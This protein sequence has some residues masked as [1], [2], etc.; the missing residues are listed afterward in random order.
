MNCEEV[1]NRYL[2]FKVTFEELLIN[3]ISKPL[4][5]Q[6]RI[7]EFAK[8][9]VQLVR[10]N[11]NTVQNAEREEYIEK[12][13]NGNFKWL[14]DFNHLYDRK[15]FNI[16]SLWEDMEYK[17]SKYFNKKNRLEDEF[18]GRI[19]LVDKHYK[20]IVNL[21]TY[22]REEFIRTRDRFK[23]EEAAEFLSGVN[24][25][26]YE[27]FRVNFNGN[28]L[29]IKIGGKESAVVL[30]SMFSMFVDFITIL[31][32]NIVGKK[33][34]SNDTEYQEYKKSKFNCML[35]HLNQIFNELKTQYYFC[36]YGIHNDNYSPDFDYLKNTGVFFGG[37][38]VKKE[39]EE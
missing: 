29:R 35:L 39:F 20:Q 16:T 36:P 23:E 11:C 18:D 27:I 25:I 21:I 38:K 13:I 7:I 17:Y 15:M 31:L 9:M 2:M 8:D 1:I 3:P 22:F 24:S 37:G 33:S 14:D 32:N 10:F 30:N 28:K 12:I 26:P 19:E 5:H 4:F 34:L 6:A